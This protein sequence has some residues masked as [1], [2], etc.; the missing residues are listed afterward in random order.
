[1][2]IK[3]YFFLLNNF[4]YVDYSPRKSME[5]IIMAIADAAPKEKPA[6]KGTPI[7]INRTI[8]TENPENNTNAMISII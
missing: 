6:E 7:V 1:V 8:P 5:I 2:K 3:S 4:K